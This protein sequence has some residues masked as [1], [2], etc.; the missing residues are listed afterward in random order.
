MLTTLLTHGE[1]C[2]VSLVDD[3]RAIGLPMNS[4]YSPFTRVNRD[5]HEEETVQYF[6][7]FTHDEAKAERAHE[8]GA[9]IRPYRSRDQ[10]FS[11]WEVVAGVTL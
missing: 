7:Q 8:L 1:G 5:T 2:A 11:G 6:V 9:T 10:Q 4:W 3:L